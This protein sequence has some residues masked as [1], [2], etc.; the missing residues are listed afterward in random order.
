M[1]GFGLGGAASSGLNGLG[2]GGV[3]RCGTRGYLESE[4]FADFNLVADKGCDEL[5]AVAVLDAAYG[6]HLCHYRYRYSVS[7]P[8]RMSIGCCAIT[9]RLLSFKLNMTF[10]IFADKGHI[11]IYCCPIKIFVRVCAR[12]AG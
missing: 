12:E 9:I 11:F 6:A 4:C 10:T 2:F 7:T 8:L 3:C 5:H 1:L